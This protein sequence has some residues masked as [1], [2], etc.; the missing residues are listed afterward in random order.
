MTKILELAKQAG[1]YIPQKP[2]LPEE[3]KQLDRLNEFARL[4]LLN[5]R[6]VV[7]ENF[8]DCNTAVK[9]DRIIREEFGVE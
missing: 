9:M 5:C 6:S 7:S 8:H 3:Q 2:V 4:I 1:F